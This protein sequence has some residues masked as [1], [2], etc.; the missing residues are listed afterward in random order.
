[1]KRG[2]LYFLSI[3]LHTLAIFFF[4]NEIIHLNN[5]MLHNI[6][7]ESQSELLKLSIS[8]VIHFENSNS[9]DSMVNST[10]LFCLYL[11]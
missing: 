7:I 10:W 1:M 9:V 6:N 2:S 11:I 5:E 8:C 4:F 3:K